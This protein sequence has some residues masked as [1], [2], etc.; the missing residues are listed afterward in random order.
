[1]KRKVCIRKDD[2]GMLFLSIKTTNEHGT[3]EHGMTITPEEY[4]QMKEA[5]KEFDNQ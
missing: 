2:E 3:A 5:I 1:M 4:E